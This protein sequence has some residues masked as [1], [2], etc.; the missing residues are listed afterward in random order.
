[1]QVRYTVKD[2]AGIAGNNVESVKDFSEVRKM[3]ASTG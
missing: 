3:F 1:M 2:L